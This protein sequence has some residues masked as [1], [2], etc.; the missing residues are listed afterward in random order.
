LELNWGGKRET[1]KGARQRN[2]KKKGA[3]QREVAHY[4]DGAKNIQGEK[5]GYN[6]GRRDGGNGRGTLET[7]GVSLCRGGL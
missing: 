1:K 3:Y 6:Q 7:S 5:K 2:R 4:S